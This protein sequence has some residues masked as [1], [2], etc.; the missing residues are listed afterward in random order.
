MLQ[1]NKADH[2]VNFF[3]W[4]AYRNLQLE[5]CIKGQWCVSK[6]GK[7]A[8]L[9]LS[10]HLCICILLHRGRFWSSDPFIEVQCFVP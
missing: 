4:H 1:F 6:A 2:S 7:G 8:R 3:F 10:A 5:L 9:P